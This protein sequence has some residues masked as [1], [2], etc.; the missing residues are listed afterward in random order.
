[1]KAV[2]TDNSKFEGVIKNELK[3]MELQSQSIF[4]VNINITFW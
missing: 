2:R 1:M 3:G 4:V